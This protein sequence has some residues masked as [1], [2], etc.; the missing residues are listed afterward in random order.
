MT[1]RESSS[2][3]IDPLDTLGKTT[4]SVNDNFLYRTIEKIHAHKDTEDPK[5]DLGR[6]DFSVQDGNDDCIFKC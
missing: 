2:A 6:L 1:D 5:Y 3:T 4:E